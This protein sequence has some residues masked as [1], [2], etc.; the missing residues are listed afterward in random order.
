MVSVF[1]RR[2]ILILYVQTQAS[3]YF[4]NPP[5]QRLN[6]ENLAVIIILSSNLQCNGNILPVLQTRELNAKRPNKLG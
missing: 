2:M 5:N 1:N 4:C 6:M 3:V